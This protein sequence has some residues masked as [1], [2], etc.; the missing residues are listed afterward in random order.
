MQDSAFLS[1]TELKKLV[2]PSTIKYIREGAFEN[3]VNMTQ[4]VLSE[5]EER[6]DA[7]GDAFALDIA[8]SILAYLDADD[9]S[10]QN[11]RQERLGDALF[12]HDALEHSII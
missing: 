6:L 1:C 8:E 7:V 5:G 12:F 9:F 10:L 4:L 11:R 2:V 3:C